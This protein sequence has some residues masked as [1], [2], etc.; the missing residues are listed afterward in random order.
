MTSGIPSCTMFSSVP[1]D[2]LFKVIVFRISPGKFGSSKLSVW[3]MRS[4]GRQFEVF[5]AERVALAGGKI[6]ERHPVAAPDLGVQVVNLSRKSVRRQPFD[7][8]IRFQECPI[9][10]LG[11]RSQ[12]TMKPGGVR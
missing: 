6:R 9:D 7:Q 2:T 1:Q 8:R 3:R 12:Q 5:S 11:R 10:S 4:G